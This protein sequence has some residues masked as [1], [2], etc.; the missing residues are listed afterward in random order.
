MVGLLFFAID[1]SVVH[2]ASCIVMKSTQAHSRDSNVLY[3]PPPLE[4][5]VERA[6][7]RHTDE[8]SDTDQHGDG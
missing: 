4:I 6:A 2:I 3:D 5:I 1:D 7:H 8:Y